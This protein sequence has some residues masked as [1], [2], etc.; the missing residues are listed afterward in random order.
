MKNYD[1][2]YYKLFGSDFQVKK[3][4]SMF[5]DFVNLLG[6]FTESIMQY[7]DKYKL[8]KNE[9]YE[10]A[11]VLLYTVGSIGKFDNYETKGGVENEQVV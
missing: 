9:T 10:H 2:S 3:D 6:D 4:D 11:V 7:A 1:N 8:N 5:N